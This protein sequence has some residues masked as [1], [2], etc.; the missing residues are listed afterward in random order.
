MANER[1]T[2]GN[3]GS[4][5]QILQDGGIDFS[6]S[7]VVFEVGVRFLYV[8]EA[9]IIIVVGILL[10]RYGRR[11]LQRIQVKYESQ[12]MG[13]NLLE[14]LISGFLVIVTATLALKVV[15]LDLTLLVSALTLGLSFALGDIIKNYVSGILILFKSPFSIGD[16]VKIKSFVGTVERVDFQST[17]LKTFDRREITIYN[18]DILSRSITN[19]T[20]E[21]MRRL[22]IGVTLGRGTD[23]SRAMAIFENILQNHAKVLKKPHFSVVF[24]R[25]AA[26][27]MTFHI[28]F[29]VQRPVNILKVRSEIALQIEQAFDEAQIFSPYERQIQFT[30]DVSMNDGRKHRLQRFYEQPAMAAIAAQTVAQVQTVTTV[31]DTELADQDEPEFEAAEFSEE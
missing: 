15:G 17:T 21:D 12:R 6:L 20:K 2:A 8:L 22:T 19:F 23:M 3:I 10:I 16:V 25:F 14:K 9:V 7:N 31:A 1:I 28:R 11:Y 29:W 30:E 5:G 4:N 26:S 18:K 13:L 24:K 27:G